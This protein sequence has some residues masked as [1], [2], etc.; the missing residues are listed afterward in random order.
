VNDIEDLL[1]AAYQQAVTSVAPEDLRPAPP[2]RAR[3]SRPAAQRKHRVAHPVLAAIAVLVVAA[4]AALIPQFMSQPVKRAPAN[5]A[6]PVSE[7]RFFAALPQTGHA[8]IEF[9]NAMTG[10]VTGQIPLPRP[11]GHYTAVAAE[12]DGRT[13][14][15]SESGGPVAHRYLFK[16]R[17]DEAGRPGPLRPMPQQL[18]GRLSLSPMALSPDGSSV[19]Y[20]AATSGPGP[21][22]NLVLVNLTTGAR[23]TWQGQRGVYLQNLA[24]S[25]HGA[26]ISVSGWFPSYVKADAV[27]AILRSAQKNAKIARGAVLVHRLSH[28]ALSP[29]GA[30]LYACSMDRRSFELSAYD[31]ASKKRLAVLARWPQS[32]GTCGMAMAPSGRYL[33]LGDVRGRLRI[34]DISTG[35]FSKSSATAVR[36]NYDLAW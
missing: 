29:D 2:A 34:F 30:V 7:P 20:L 1:R 31:V 5:G 32:T 13:F 25:D 9:L 23:K 22:Q 18:R 12:P 26:V 27:T 10:K 8:P 36:Y 33:L 11:M 6:L 16:V 24:L 4:A 21:D 3:L 35:R 17:L 28:M 14:L 19:A 15:V